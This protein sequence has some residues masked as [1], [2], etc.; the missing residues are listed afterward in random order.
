MIDKNVAAKLVKLAKEMLDFSYSPYSEYKVGAAL[1]TK[2]GKIYLGCN[3]ENA[4]YSPTVC[5][6]RVAFSTAIHAGKKSFSAIAVVGGKD[7][8][9]ICA[10]T[11]PC[12][13]CR[14]F[15][16]E[17]CSPD[18]PVILSNGKSSKVLTLG[19]LLPESFTKENLF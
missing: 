12:G 7:S 14:Q 11:P 13:V 19:E 15:M 4:S 18:F 9:D 17:F 5:A 3:I 6:E 10:Y 2:S 16:A 8:E 1:L